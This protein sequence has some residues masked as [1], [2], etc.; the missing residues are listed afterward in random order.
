MAD[1]PTFAKPAA[2]LGANI[3]NAAQPTPGQGLVLDTNGKLAALALTG[4]YNN[5]A[6]VGNRTAVNFVS[7]ATLADNPGNDRVDVTIASGPTTYR[8]TTAKTVSNSVAETD[9]LNGE[10]T[11]AAGALGT[12]GVLRLTAIGDFLNSAGSFGLPKFKLKLGAG[13]TVVFDTS[14]AATAASSATRFGWKVVVTLHNLGAANSQALS[15]EWTIGSGSPGA[16]TANVAFTTGEGMTT[17]VRDATLA[18][19]HGYAV[20]TSAIDTTAAMAVVLSVI[21]GTNSAS[22]ETKLYGALVE[23]V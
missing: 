4:V 14:A 2:E 15:F 21:N 16:G 1:D 17:L 8:K 13:A 19:Y 22:Y 10:I 3:P 12:T 20:N 11:V 5:G 6:L 18:R 23:V 7:G 9:L